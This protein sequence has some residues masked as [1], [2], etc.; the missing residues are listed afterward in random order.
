M[1]IVEL[2]KIGPIYGGI[3][4]LDGRNF[5]TDVST[6]LCDFRLFSKKWTL[7]HMISDFKGGGGISDD[8]FIKPFI[9]QNLKNK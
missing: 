2:L 3:W 7:G 9:P 5:N 8:V 4:T 6:F 1:I